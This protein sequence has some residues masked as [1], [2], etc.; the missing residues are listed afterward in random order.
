MIAAGVSLGDD[1]AAMDASTGADVDDVVGAADRFLVVLDDDHRVADVAQLLQRLQQALVVALVQTDRRFVEDIEHAGQPRTDLR[2]QANALRLA[3]GE[4]FRR[5][6]ERQIVEAD[7]DQE[8]QA[9]DDFLEHFLGDLGLVPRQL[10]RDEVVARFGQRQA[11]E[12]VQGARTGEAADAHIARFFAQAAAVAR[13]AAL[14]TDQACQLFANG[15]RVGFLVAPFE[16][17]DDAFESCAGE[18]CAGHAR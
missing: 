14:V 9:A 13:G 10:Q 8:L 3:A 7:V 15:L 6:V 5:T 4:R 18:C 2:G 11:A 16:V 1:V 12:L 17:D